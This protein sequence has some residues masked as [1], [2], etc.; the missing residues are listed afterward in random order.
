MLCNL[1]CAEAP[2][3]SPFL[4]Q[5]AQSGPSLPARM[6]TQLQPVPQIPKPPSTLAVAPS[7]LPLLRCIFWVLRETTA[8]WCLP[9]PGTRGA[10]EYRCVGQ[11]TLSGLLIFLLDSLPSSILSP[12][13]SPVYR[14]NVPAPNV[15]VFSRKGLT[16]VGLFQ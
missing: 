15:L 2:M 16:W 4:C 5:L 7:F 3:L 6:G 1:L 10:W 8:I 14:S 13:P 12:P 11:V 9:L